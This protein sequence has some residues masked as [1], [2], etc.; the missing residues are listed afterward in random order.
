MVRTVNARFANGVL[1]PLE[2]VDFPE[3][4]LL[5]LNIEEVHVEEPK[6][7][8]LPGR[9]VP[10]RSGFLPGMDDP[11]SMKQ[12]IEDEDAQHYLDLQERDSSA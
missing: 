7:P 12:L 11:K 1:T 9:I 5:V 10:N 2:P 6:T 3:G 8:T 4:A